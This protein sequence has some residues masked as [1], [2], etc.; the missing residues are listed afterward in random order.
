MR[1]TVRFDPFDLRK[2]L[3][4]TQRGERLEAFPVDLSGNR[5]VRRN[6]PSEPTKKV[7]PAPL[8]SLEDLAEEIDRKSS[9]DEKEHT[10]E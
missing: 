7:P 9:P 3:I 10:D 4:V 5:R 8:A 1:V 2:V 6:P